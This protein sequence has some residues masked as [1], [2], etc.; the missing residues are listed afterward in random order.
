MWHEWGRGAYKVLVGKAERK[1]KPLGILRRLWE[2]DIK[3]DF[4]EIGWEGVDW[5]NLAHDR[6]KWWAVVNT[7]MNHRVP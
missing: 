6:F 2:D 4:K 3:A 5:N 1:K 7:V